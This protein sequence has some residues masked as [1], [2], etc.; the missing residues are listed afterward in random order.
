[1]RCSAHTM[2]Q[3]AP[4]KR[5]CPDDG[6]FTF[7]DRSARADALEVSRFSCTLFSDVHEVFDYAEP[8]GHSR[9]AQPPVLPSHRQNG[10]GTRLHIFGAQSSSPP[11][12]LSSLQLSP[13]RVT[14]QDSRPRWSR[15]SFSVGLFHP[16]QCAGLARRSLSPELTTQRPYK[17][18]NEN[19]SAKRSGHYQTG[20][21]MRCAVT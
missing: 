18:V 12:P 3:S 11:V 14:A 19:E 7:P 21:L 10:V 9:L 2:A 13:S 1:M 8:D 4:P 6:S 20:P 5:T 17:D 16:L 15:F